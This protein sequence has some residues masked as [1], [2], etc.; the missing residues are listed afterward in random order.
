MKDNEALRLELSGFQR[1]QAEQKIEQVKIALSSFVE[2]ESD[3][4][5]PSDLTIRSAMLERSLT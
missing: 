2:L 3:K 5:K 4:R 1:Q